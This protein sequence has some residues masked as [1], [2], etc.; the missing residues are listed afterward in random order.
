VYYDIT[1]TYFEGN[2]CILAEYG[3][4]RDKR[5]DK[6]QVVLAL[7]TDKYGFPIY[8]KVFPG[9][10]TDNTTVDFISKELSKEYK[11]I[12]TI[13]V[14]DRGMI[15]N[16][17]FQKITKNKMNYLMALSRSHIKK[18][19]SIHQNK[20]NKMK[21]KEIK[22]IKLEDVYLFIQYSEQLKIEKQKTRNKKIEK[23]KK[24]LEFLKEKFI[25]K[26]KKYSSFEEIYFWLGKLNNQL[27]CKKYYNIDE[28]K[29]EKNKLN[30]I[31]NNETIKDEEK[32]DGF[33]V[34]E[35]S[36]KTMINKNSLNLYKNL[37]KVENS[38]KHLKSDLDIRP[39]YHRNDDT[40][41]GHIY[42]CILAYF[43]ENYISWILNNKNNISTQPKTILDELSSLSIIEKKKEN[44]IIYYELTECSKTNSKILKCFGIKPKE[45]EDY[46]NKIHSKEK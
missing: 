5:K 43:I 34:L 41:S 11:L 12:N 39:I 19:I 15:S 45:I 40:V 6:K 29:K 2:T 42:S 46:I 30:F 4:S 22:I 23:M 13:I 38:F 1:S 31:I 26:H 3:Y 28:T 7:V 35:S 21:D 33:I 14:G 27:S 37:I 44:E 20:L 17:N 8:A 32:Y 18:K 25:K 9:N 16:E 10:T 24:R 36:L